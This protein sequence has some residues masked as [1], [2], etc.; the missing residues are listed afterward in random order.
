[1]DKV[2]QDG[3]KLIVESRFGV[4]LPWQGPAMLNGRPW[5]VRNDTTLWI[6]SGRNVIEPGQK[7]PAWHILDFNGNLRS[8]SASTDSLKFSYQ[9]SARALALLNARPGSNEIDG[10]GTQPALVESGSNFILL[11]PRG[12]HVVQVETAG[13][14]SIAVAY[15]S[16]E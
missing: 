16:G 7:E 12:Q 8:A 15:R 11:L 6:P 5:P 3:P 4:G 1:V 9:S 13:S 10:A 2:V 14:A